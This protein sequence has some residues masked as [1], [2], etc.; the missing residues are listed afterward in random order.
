MPKKTIIHFRYFLSETKRCDFRYYSWII[1]SP[2]SFCVFVRS[3]GTRERPGFIRH[4]KKNLSNVQK[5]FARFIPQPTVRQFELE[6][7]FKTV[8]KIGFFTQKNNVNRV[9]CSST[10]PI[11]FLRLLS[12]S[13]KNTISNE[14]KLLFFTLRDLCPAINDRRVW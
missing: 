10:R 7:I 3:C 12:T 5:V 14:H 6:F 13:E 8:T 9:L 2:Y 4:V 1:V 11:D